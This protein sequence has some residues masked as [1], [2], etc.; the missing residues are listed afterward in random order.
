MRM[1]WICYNNVSFKFCMHP[2][3]NDSLLCFP[4][5]LTSQNSLNQTDRL[6]AHSQVKCW[7]VGLC[8]QLHGRITLSP[9]CILL[10]KCC[11]DFCFICVVLVMYQLSTIAI[12]GINGA[13]ALYYCTHPLKV[14]KQLFHCSFIVF[15]LAIFS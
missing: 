5:K 10:S 6:I 11:V 2:M 7:F 1:V 8:L 14:V 15:K 4:P 3:K 12:L 9:T 13:I